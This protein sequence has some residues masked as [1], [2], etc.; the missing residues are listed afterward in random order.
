M[1]DEIFK[2][3]LDQ[4]SLLLKNKTVCLTIDGWSN[5]RNEPII[6]ACVVNEDGEV[7]LINTT[8]TSGNSHTSEYLTNLT[9][10]IIKEAEDKFSCCV[11]SVV[12]DNAANMAKMRSLVKDHPNGDIIAYG[13]SA[14]LLNLL[15]KDLNVDA[16]MNHV[17]QI[18]KYFRNNHLAKALLSSNGGSA[19]SLPLEVRWSSSCNCLESF[20]QNW[21]ILVKICEEHRNDIDRDIST[22]VSN[23]SIK[24]N[25]EDLL[26]RLKPISC[27]LDLI[28]Q[29]QCTIAHC[30]VIWKKLLIKLNEK[31]DSSADK[32][33]VM[34]RYSQ[35]ITPYHI[36]AHMLSPSNCNIKDNIDLTEEEKQ[37]A[38]AVTR[39]DFPEVMP[40][41]LRFQ[42]KVPPYDVMMDETV[43]SS[44]RDI[45]WWKAA[46][47]V[48]NIDSTAQNIIKQLMT[49]V[50]S[51]AGVERM[52]ST[53]GLVHS[54]LR[55]R[56]GVDKAGKLT[57][58]MKMFNRPKGEKSQ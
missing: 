34:S 52:F 44:M 55:N 54:D 45:E 56:L 15:A 49:A 16:V 26:G 39:K 6:C 21:H 20:L 14:H 11:R 37:N 58:L 36:I 3:E 41:L 46:F 19:L 23:I 35:A 47:S 32:K 48:T 30:V 18:M 25:A 10:K 43:T 50:G 9:L 57:F 22:L 2:E 12:T 51:S 24:R 38:L 5:I 27:A 17:V 31:L 29:D 40:T 42:A 53:F 4:C 7:F 1:L 8:D 13:C 28:Q 33:K